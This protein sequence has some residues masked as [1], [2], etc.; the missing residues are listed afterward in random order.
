VLPVQEKRTGEKKRSEGEIYGSRVLFQ[1]GLQREGF[2]KKNRHHFH[3]K[4]SPSC[5]TI[6]SIDFRGRRAR[7]HEITPS[8]DGEQSLLG[9]FAGE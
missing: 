6:R 7:L 8:G 3:V 9:R 4:E 1:L 5:F 2:S